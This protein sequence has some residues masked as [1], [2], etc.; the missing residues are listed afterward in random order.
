MQTSAQVLLHVCAHNLLTLTVDILGSVR[1]VAVGLA[2]LGVVVAWHKSAKCLPR[3]SVL[4]RTN[5][6]TGSHGEVGDRSKDHNQGGDDVIE[7]LGNGDSPRQAGKDSAGNDHKDEDN[8]AASQYKMSS[9]QA[10]LSRLHTKGSSVRH[11]QRPGTQ[12]RW[13]QWSGWGQRS[14]LA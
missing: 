4:L 3:K 5:A 9:R 8:P 12:A 13:G 6:V 1:D 14:S 11:L 7:A 10:M 2:D